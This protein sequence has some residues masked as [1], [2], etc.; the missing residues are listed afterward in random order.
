MVKF[1]SSQTLVIISSMHTWA[2][3][4]YLVEVRH[5][6]EG[7]DAAWIIVQASRLVV[8]DERREVEVRG[9]FEERG[10]LGVGE[11][12]GF[13]IELKELFI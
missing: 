7:R 6:E 9:R 11:V 3:D 10:H 4:S 5:E 1:K 12:F 13:A 8:F 2:A